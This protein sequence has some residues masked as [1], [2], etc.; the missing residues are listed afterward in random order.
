MGTPI[1]PRKNEFGKKWEGKVV[2]EK[3]PLRQ[4]LGG[5]NHSAVFLSEPRNGRS[6]KIVVKLIPSA[7]LDED[8]QLSRWADAAKLSHPHLIRL[9]ESGRCAIDGTRLLYVVMEYAEE[10]L[11]EVLP[12][13]PLGPE[14]A[15]EML[16]PAAEALSAL[17]RSGFVH[18]RIMPSNIMAVGDQLKLSADG[19]RKI[20]EPSIASSP[21]AYGAPEVAT[22]GL[23][24]AADVW[25]L[26]MT[27]IAVLTQIEPKPASGEGRQVVVPNSIPQPLRG[28][29]SQCLQVDPKLRCTVGEI[30]GQ[31]QP[32]G[33]TPSK[34]AFEAHI[35][36]EFPKRW[37][38]PA[39]MIVALLLAVWLGGKA[40][41][42]KSQVPATATHSADQ[43]GAA[44]TPA[45]SSPAPFSQKQSP[46]QKAAT[47]GSVLHQVMPEVSR[48]AQKTITG[49]LK[50]SVKVA[51]DTAGNVTDARFVSPGPSRY[52]SARALAAARGWK[53]TPPRVGGQA[54]TSEWLLRFQF[55][56]ASLEVF[57]AQTKP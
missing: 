20:W 46:A 48:N 14:E 15:E 13:R 34:K 9:F 23:S 55:S 8:A 50:V 54:V 3:F 47:R 25:S 31:L 21:G 57:P 44:E 10:N 2:D 28:I 40:L 53:F 5:S 26:G 29:A 51:V 49:H 39:I 30:L 35:R 41:L 7:G 33:A 11:A 32:E 17:H 6:Q 24:T 37:L 52:F 36:R 45:P 12:L 27:L 38:L 19:L 42:H 16:R 43:P 4:W 56:R 22:V 18:G 1:D